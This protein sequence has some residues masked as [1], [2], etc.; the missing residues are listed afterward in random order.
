M[1]SGAEATDYGEGTGATSAP[2]EENSHYAH[3]RKALAEF[4]GRANI[5]IESA[6]LKNRVYQ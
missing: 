4:K 1:S 2:I 6:V 3:V 5:A